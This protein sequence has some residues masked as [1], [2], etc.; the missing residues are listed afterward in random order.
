[1]KLVNRMVFVL[2][3]FLPSLAYGDPSI[4]FVRETH[5]FGVVMQ[6]EKL[7]YTFEFT[8]TGTEELV[9]EKIESS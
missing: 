7:E 4:E 6:G 3:L 5:D 2:M 9:I 8:N 1:M